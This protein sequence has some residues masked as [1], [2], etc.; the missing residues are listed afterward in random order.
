MSDTTETTEVETTTEETS[1][2]PDPNKSLA[3]A[4][5][6][7]VR[8]RDSARE[9]LATAA[10]RI[11]AL[12]RREVERL[13]ADVL[14]HPADLFSLSGNEVADYL[15]EDGD[16]D[17][18]KVA[19]DVAAVLAE[20]PGLRKQGRASDPSQGFGGSPP[21]PKGSPSMAALI[22][23]TAHNQSHWGSPKRKLTGRL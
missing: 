11:E 16:V 10:A 7:Y 17:A 3:E 14:S 13:A 2:T 5:A 6:R 15:T 12:H 19:A 20:R 8:E 22:K 4:N 21:P 9:E 1:Q 18:D 23:E